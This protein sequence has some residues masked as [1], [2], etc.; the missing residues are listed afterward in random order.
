MLATGRA[1]WRQAGAV[2]VL[3]FPE[4]LGLRPVSEWLFMDIGIDGVVSM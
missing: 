1:D 2:T 3:P 4:Y